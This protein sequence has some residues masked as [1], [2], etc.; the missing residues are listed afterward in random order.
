[1]SCLH[2]CAYR[3]SVQVYM[4]EI[5]EKASD[6]CFSLTKLVVAATVQLCSV[7][8][9]RK[10]ALV[11]SS[12]CAYFLAHITSGPHSRRLPEFK[13]QVFAMA[14]LT[15]DLWEHKK[16]SLLLL[17]CMKCVCVCEMWIIHQGY[18]SLWALR[19]GFNQFSFS[20]TSDG[21]FSSV[22]S[23][24]W[25]T[26]TLFYITSFFVHLVIRCYQRAYVSL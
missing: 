18:C 19:I 15:S 12:R 25:K 4:L 5:C 9:L 21:F 24:Y 10:E 20:S 7:F 14:N 2:R 16:G 1:M 13:I 8:P 11:R 17:V 22:I 23:F 3:G 26:V 6:K